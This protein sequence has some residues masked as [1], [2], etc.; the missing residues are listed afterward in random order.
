MTMPTYR[1]VGGPLSRGTKIID[2]AT[3]LELRGVTKVTLI[4]DAADESH[5]WR[6]EIVLADIEVDITVPK[7]PDFCVV[8]GL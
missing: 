5:L 1:I 8:R 6:A 7:F 4:A 3:G 2:T